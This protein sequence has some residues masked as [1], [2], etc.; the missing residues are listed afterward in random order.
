MTL[1]AIKHFELIY[2]ISCNF[3]VETA[4]FCYDLS[5]TLKLCCFS[6][7]QNRLITFLSFYIIFA[8]FPPL[9]IHAVLSIQSSRGI[10]TVC[11]LTALSHLCT[12]GHLT[13]LTPFCM[14][15]FGSLCGVRCKGVKRC[16]GGNKSQRT[17]SNACISFNRRGCVASL[18]SGLC[19]LS[20]NHITNSQV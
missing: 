12:E 15:E 1:Y 16:K 19:H 18:L 8:F 11:T 5:I 2:Q 13:L 10:F 14:V 6:L 17:L 9:N 4:F 20:V 7:Y 3:K